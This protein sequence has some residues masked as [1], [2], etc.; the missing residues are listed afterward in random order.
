M[1]VTFLAVSTSTDI[2]Y[3]WNLG[4]TQ[5]TGVGSPY[6]YSFP[7]AGTYTVN[8]SMVNQY[9]CKRD[10]IVRNYVE[11]YHVPIAEFNAN[12]WSTSIL[13]PLITFS[14]QS[15]GAAQYIWDFGDQAPASNTTTTH[16]SHSYNN[17]GDYNVFLVAINNKGCKDT[18]VHRVEITPDHAVFIPNTFTPDGNGKNDMFNV[19]GV[20]IDE[21]RF[22]MEIF[23]RW[24]ELIFNSNTFRKGW[25]GTV[26]GSSVDAQEG[27]YIY[28]ILVTDIDG[29]KKNYVGHVTLLRQQ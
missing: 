4:S 13:S 11:V 10:T 20:G 28:K 26:K 17:V 16:T 19:Y 3:T 18:V 15:Q 22:K 25:D 7:E 23:D 14:N 12:P 27:V 2:T 9:G 29:N 6:T 8:L 1:N 21:D 5:T 24:G